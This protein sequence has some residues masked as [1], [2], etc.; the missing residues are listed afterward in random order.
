M[1]NTTAGTYYRFYNITDTSGNN[2]V[3]QIRTINVVDTTAPIITIVGNAEID[4]NQGE[5][6]TD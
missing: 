4:I 5:I 2:A 3:Q 1:D 6:Y